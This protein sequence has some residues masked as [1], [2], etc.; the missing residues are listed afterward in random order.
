MVKGKTTTGFEFCVNANKIK[1][2]RFLM[3]YKKMVKTG[4]GTDLLDLIPLILGDEQTEALIAHCEKD[5]ISS[6]DD[7]G[8]EFG[9]IFQAM[10]AGEETK[11]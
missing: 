9:E 2:V 11:N 3:A 4:D 6:I 7:V 5:G 8:T 10:S 1:D